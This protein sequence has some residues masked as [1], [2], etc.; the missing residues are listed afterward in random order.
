MLAAKNGELQE[1]RK[2]DSTSQNKAFDTLRSHY[3]NVGEF[4]KNKAD[5][6]A[7][8][9]S[10][11]SQTLTI[12]QSTSAIREISEGDGDLRSRLSESGKDEIT[13]LAKVFNLLMNNLQNLVKEIKSDTE[14][15]FRS[16]TLLTHASEQNSEIISNQNANLDNIASAV[17]ELSH[18]VKEVV[19]NTDTVSKDMSTVQN[20]SR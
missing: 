17:H 10:N 18:T 7:K 4:I 13:D 16:E 3:D 20:M 2:L 14:N 11:K 19:G 8:D 15:M 1:A 5:S 6:M 9:A 12:S